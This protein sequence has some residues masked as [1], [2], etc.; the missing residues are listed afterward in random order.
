MTT[1]SPS[2][3]EYVKSLGATHVFDYNSPDCAADIRQEVPD[4]KY[5]LDCASKGS[6]GSICAASLAPGAGTVYRSLLP[7]E[8]FPRNDVDTAIIQSFEIFG[9]PFFFGPNEV[10]VRREAFEFAKKLMT[11]ATRMVA[12]GKL[13]PHKLDVREGGLEGVL[14]G[15]EELKAGKIRGAKVVVKV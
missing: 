15:L 7:V 10:P 14:K 13:K 2:S 12:D 3:F 5:C 8:D 4:L 6:S 1:C 9:K 11:A